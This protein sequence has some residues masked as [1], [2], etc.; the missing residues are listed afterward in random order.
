MQEKHYAH[1]NRLQPQLIS[2]VLRRDHME[3][4]AVLSQ[5]GFGILF[6]LEHNMA[7]QGDFHELQHGGVIVVVDLRTIET[8]IVRA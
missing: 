2:E 8:F 3:L 4:I 7:W 5:Q 6:H 1:Q